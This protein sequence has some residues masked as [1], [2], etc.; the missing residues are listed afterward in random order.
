[1]ISYGGRRTALFFYF[2]F[3]LFFFKCVL[4][5]DRAKLTWVVLDKVG[6]ASSG[7][8]CGIFLGGLFERLPGQMSHWDKLNPLTPESGTESGPDWIS[9]RWVWSFTEGRNSVAPSEETCPLRKL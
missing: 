6:M 8:E 9:S 7:Q 4:G 1:M 2:Y 3:I 5:W